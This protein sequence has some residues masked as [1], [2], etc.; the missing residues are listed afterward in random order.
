MSVASNMQATRMEA[1]GA[2]R[3]SAHQSDFYR[4]AIKAMGVIALLSLVGTAT[5]HR[6]QESATA[7]A[8]GSAELRACAEQDIRIRTLIDDLGDVDVEEA[9]RV[10][11]EL[12]LRGLVTLDVR[13]P[14]DSVAL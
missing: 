12:L 9:D 1:G 5:L 3:T 6:A 7:S 8:A 10:A 11:L 4:F 13:Q 2:H 14:S